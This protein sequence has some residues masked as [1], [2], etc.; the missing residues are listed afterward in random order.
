MGGHQ[1]PMQEGQA[2]GAFQEPSRGGRPLAILHPLPLGPEPMTERA[3]GD[4]QLSGNFAARRP[5]GIELLE[6][7]DGLCRDDPEWD[8]LFR[9]G[10]DKSKIELGIH[11]L[12]LLSWSPTTI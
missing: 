6:L 1:Y 12:D 9:L 5:R 2:L 7:L 11:G 8:R 10:N 4:P 3:I